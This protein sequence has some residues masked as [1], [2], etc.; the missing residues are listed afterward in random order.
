[1]PECIPDVSSP[2]SAT[3][4]GSPS[5]A[6]P[7]CGAIC[8]WP[9]WRPSAG[10]PRWPRSAPGWWPAATPPQSAVCAVMHKLLRRMMGRIRA[11]YAAIRDRETASALPGQSHLNGE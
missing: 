9:R 5:R 10:T 8:G 3:T 1:M 2:G 11:H 6:T 4:A 7:P